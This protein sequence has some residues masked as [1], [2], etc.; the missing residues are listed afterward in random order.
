MGKERR[1]MKL[2]VL[3]KEEV[4]IEPGASLTRMSTVIEKYEDLENLENKLTRENLKVAN[5]VEEDVTVS[6]F[7]DMCAIDP[8]FTIS[9]KDGKTLATFGIRK[10]TEAELQEND[11]NT[12]I[13]YLSD[14][15]AVTVK[16]LYP[17]YDPNG[18]SYKT[19]D[20]ANINGIL[21]KCLQDHISQDGWEPGNAPSLWV[22]LNSGEHEGT[23]EDPIPVPDTVTTAGYEYV[24]GKY[25]SENGT[26][27]LC[28]RGGVDNPE[29][30]YGQKEILYY[31]P[32]ALVG[33]YFEVA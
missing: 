12:A 20:R 11:V 19:G 22:A 32:S 28:K 17:E 7:T 18:K 26:T 33:Q 14:E 23:K 29:E 9:K 21:Y 31:G 1:N 16:D 4:T 27:Y 13:S 25:Y 30:M 2:V 8:L 3:N 24:Y 6:T 5:F 15:Q 10:L